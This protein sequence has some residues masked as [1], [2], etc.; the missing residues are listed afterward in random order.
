M[1]RYGLRLQRGNRK[2]LDAT[3]DPIVF[4]T[5]TGKTW[6]DYINDVRLEITCARAPYLVCRYDTV[7]GYMIE[8]SQH[9]GLLDRKLR[10]V[11]ENTQTEK[12]WLKWAI[13]P[14]KEN[15]FKRLETSLCHWQSRVRF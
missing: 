15:G 13:L 11:S 4:P 5:A 14:G 8:L 6:Q 7:S 2:D 12:E 3:T 10:V 9:I 1:V